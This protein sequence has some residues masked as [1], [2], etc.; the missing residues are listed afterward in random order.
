MR[1]S[2]LYQPPPDPATSPHAA[3]ALADSMERALAGDF[4]FD[5]IDVLKQAWQLT[6]GVK[7]ILLVGIALVVIASFVAQ[8][9]VGLLAS[10]PIIAALVS[11]LLQLIVIGPI[12]GGMLVVG[13]RQATGQPFAMDDLWGQF[14]KAAPIILMFVISY[15]LMC[16]GYLL[17]ILPGIYLSVAYSMALPLVVDRGL[18]PWEALETSRKVVTKCW[19]R[20]AFLLLLCGLILAVSALPLLIPLI[21]TLPMAVLVVA[22][23]Y[24]NLFGVAGTA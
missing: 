3:G 10:G 2:D 23:A 16:V 21:W 12:Y 9:L 8:W 24:R 4:E 13:L 7:L 1:M 15:V 5:P 14:N 11:S 17:L 6:E 19:W 20:M 18:S 22:V